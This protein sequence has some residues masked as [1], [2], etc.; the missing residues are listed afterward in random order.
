MDISYRTRVLMVLRKLELEYKRGVTFRELEDYCMFNRSIV[1]KSLDSLDD[2]GI[3]HQLD[4]E[5]ILFRGTWM[6]VITTNEEHRQFID[7]M[8]LDIER[9]ENAI[10][11]EQK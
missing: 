1:S 7:N 5:M 8:I 4:A 9:L 10:E 6:K 2:M 11:G 3:V